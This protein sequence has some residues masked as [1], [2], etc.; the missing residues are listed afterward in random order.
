MAIRLISDGGSDLPK[1][2]LERYKIS[3]VPLYIHFTNEEYRS[4]LDATIFYEKLRGAKELPK[5][6]SPSPYDFLQVFTNT[7]DDE[8][9]LVISISSA[10]SS[11]YDHAL[12]AKEM[13]LEEYPNRRI[14]IID[15]RTASMGSGLLI[16]QAAKLIELG[17]SFQEVVHT[18]REKVKKTRTFFFLETLENVIKGGRLDRVKGTIANVLNI[19]LMMHASEEGKIDVLEKVRG[20]QNAIKRLIE[21]VG[22]YGKDFEEKILAVAHSNCEEKA[23]QVIQKVMSKY[24]FAEVIFSNMGP[25]IGTYAGEG[26]VLLAYE[27]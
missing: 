25:V 21:Q 16:Y 9:L 10:I 13:F 11:T 14:E 19:K 23:R 17:K 8:D 3:V 26:G 24:P 15:S 5:T 7:M 22:E 2:I 6:S 27:V 20:T 12:R 18:M 4:D 1:E